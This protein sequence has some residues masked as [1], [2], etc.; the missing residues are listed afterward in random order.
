MATRSVRGSPQ[1]QRRTV[2]HT[3]G[4]AQLLFDVAYEKADFTIAAHHEFAR[5]NKSHPGLL[6]RMAAQ[7]PLRVLPTVLFFPKGDLALASMFNAAFDD[8]YY[9][10]VTERSIETYEQFDR[11]YLRI[12]APYQLS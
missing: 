9:S 2:P 3:A 1:A 4:F 10:G 12:Q 6:R 11:S 5:F 7:L 8:L